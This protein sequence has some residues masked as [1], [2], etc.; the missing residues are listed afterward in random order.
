MIMLQD[1][2]NLCRADGVFQPVGR[3]P[4]DQYY[5]YYMKEECNYG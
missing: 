3:N 2:G 1:M 5:Q 4:L